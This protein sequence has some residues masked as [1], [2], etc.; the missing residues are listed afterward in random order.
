MRIRMTKKAAVKRNRGG[1]GGSVATAVIV[2]AENI[3]HG[4]EAEYEHIT[5]LCGPQ[6]TGWKLV[7]QSTFRAKDATYDQIEVRLANG[8]QR[9]FYFDITKLMANG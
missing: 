8:G 4:T 3:L 9:T 2:D 1:D 7:R 6:G 5:R